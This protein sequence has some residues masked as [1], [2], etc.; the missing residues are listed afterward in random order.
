MHR[1][2]HR[3]QPSSCSVTGMVIL[4][5]TVTKIETFTKTRSIIY[6][7]CAFCYIYYYYCFLFLLQIAMGIPLHRIRCVRAL[8]GESPWGDS[9]INF[10]EPKRK[11][12]PKG[13]CIAARI[14]SENPDEGMC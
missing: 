12:V 10:D 1:D 2:D 3:Y 11:P 6:Y 5:E 7:Y 8:Y 13:H 14:T 9:V 4:K